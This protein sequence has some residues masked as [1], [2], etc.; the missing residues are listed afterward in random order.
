MCRASSQAARCYDEAF[1]EAPL[2]RPWQHPETRSS[3]HLYIAR[4]DASVRQRLFEGLRDA[5]IGVNVHSVSVPGQ[6]YYRD[7]GFDP[8]D[9]PEAQRYYAEAITLP[10]FPDLRDEEQDMVIA[11]VK[12][13][14]ECV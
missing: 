1:A 2:T 12:R 14:L 9:W 3:A 6:P 13:L 10:L 5:G 7:L 4:V 11:A 8:A